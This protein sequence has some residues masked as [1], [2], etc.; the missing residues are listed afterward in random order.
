[1][2]RRRP[3]RGWQKLGSLRRRLPCGAG[4]RVRNC[5]TRSSRSSTILVSALIEIVA[6]GK[7]RRRIFRPEP[8]PPI[9]QPARHPFCPL[10]PQWARDRG[11][12]PRGRRGA[13]VLFHTAVALDW[14][15][16]ANTVDIPCPEVDVKMQEPA[17]KLGPA[18]AR[19]VSQ[20]R[21]ARPPVLRSLFVSSTSVFTHALP[22]IQRFPQSRPPSGLCR[23][24]VQ[25]A[26]AAGHVVR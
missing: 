20:A 9:Q 15:C 18:A 22:L 14:R 23:S 16:L 26:K 19:F 13:R 1:M 8:L 6:N 7:A 21:R 11:R 17:W 3:N 4:P 24:L 25:E 12:R 10:P 5:D 2:R